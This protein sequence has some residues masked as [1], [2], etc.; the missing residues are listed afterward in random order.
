MNSTTTAT[1]PGLTVNLRSIENTLA[2]L[3]TANYGKTGWTYVSV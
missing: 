2:Y 3:T 1:N